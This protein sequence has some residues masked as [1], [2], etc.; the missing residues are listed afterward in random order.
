MQ[1]DLSLKT[2][3][4][5]VWLHFTDWIYFHEKI[6]L[7]DSDLDPGLSSPVSHFS[8]CTTLEKQRDVQ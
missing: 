7:S 3:V 2:I 5:Q 1:L 4:K 6:K 8:H